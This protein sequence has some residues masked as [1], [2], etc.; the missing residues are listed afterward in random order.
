MIRAKMGAKNHSV[1]FSG[2]VQSTTVKVVLYQIHLL[3]TT[4]SAELAM[5]GVSC[6]LNWHVLSEGR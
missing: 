2:V 5:S 4:M 6:V 1:Q 3:S